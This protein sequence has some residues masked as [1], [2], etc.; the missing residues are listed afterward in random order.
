MAARPQ[1][2]P[3][4]FTGEGSWDDWIDHFESAAAVN[5]WGDADKLLW[6]RV[7]MTG[8]AQKAY[9][10]LSEAAKGD[11]ERCKGCLQERFEPASKKELYR[12][13]F[14]A[15][16]KRRTEDWASF[17]ED[18]KA[19]AERAFNNLEPDAREHL[20]LTHYLQQLGNPQVA[21]SVKQNRPKNVDEAVSATLEMESYLLPK[22]G[23]VG[24]IPGPESEQE[25]IS[26][27]AV[28]TRQ[29]S[30]MNLLQAMMERLEKLETD[31]EPNSSPDVSSYKEQAKDKPST[32]RKG[33]QTNRIICFK[34][35]KE[36][37][38]ARGCRARGQQVGN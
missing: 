12:A 6:L 27:A 35:G 17:A 20:A 10:N 32:R 3:E 15:R 22:A 38:M 29:D 25:A 4:P 9:K 14:H 36:G 30:M 33:G 31:R 11:Y 23:R 21:F 5:K 37:H 26:V 34:C 8:R 2:V 18:I 7:R 13:E 19:L 28:Q 16:R 24:H 1:V